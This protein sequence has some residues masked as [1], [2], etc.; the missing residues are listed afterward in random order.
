MTGN[1]QHK[2]ISTIKPKISYGEIFDLMGRINCQAKYGSIYRFRLVQQI[3]LFPRLQAIEFAGFDN[4]KGLSYRYGACEYICHYASRQ[5]RGVD[6]PVNIY[7]ASGIHSY[8]SNHLFFLITHP[9][10]PPENFQK[11]ISEIVAES[12][13]TMYWDPSLGYICSLSASKLKTINKVNNLEEPSLTPLI[14]QSGQSYPLFIEHE[15][16]Q[17]PKLYSLKVLF[18]G[19]RPQLFFTVRNLSSR[20]SRTISPESHHILPSLKTMIANIPT[21]EFQRSVSKEVAP[22][23]VSPGLALS[24][25]RKSRNLYYIRP[26]AQPPMN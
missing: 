6:L 20:T 9:D 26:A 19:E 5:F 3:N 13:T 24:L 2:M 4:E 15:L 8:F 16:P 7:R 23:Q 11:P 1:T 14:L 12:R 18:R 17:E 25:N 21:V 10:T 22:I